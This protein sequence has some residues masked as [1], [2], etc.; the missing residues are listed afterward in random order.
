MN[1]IMVAIFTHDSNA[2][3]F[4][5]CLRYLW[6]AIQTF[7]NATMMVG[8]PIQGKTVVLHIVDFSKK[9]QYPYELTKIIGAFLGSGLP[10]EI[11][12]VWQPAF[13]FCEN[14]NSAI[15]N[16][17][18]NDY[19]S[20]FFI[21]DDA[22]V[23]TSFLV[24]GCIGLMLHPEAVFIGGVPQEDGTW[25][26]S[27][28]DVRIP[29]LIFKTEEIL[30][31]TRLWWE[32]SAGVM[33]ITKE[34][35]LMDANFDKFFGLMGDNDLFLR[36]GKEGKKVLRDWTMRFFHCRGVTQTKFGRNPF[37]ENDPIK[38]G[39]LDY[40]KQKWGVDLSDMS[41]DTTLAD[42]P[43]EPSVIP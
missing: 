35:I 26:A 34:P 15:K 40:F 20:I 27:L 22:F 32:M 37:Q 11:K 21:N 13:G 6:R 14:V 42:F 12:L 19:E 30:N 18:V 4:Q 2:K 41:K 8:S 39:A 43:D 7:Y 9:R 24:N 28:N 5:M 3:Y 31:Y 17:F 38:R 16:A 25:N 33:R 1:K 10:L 23:E 36:M 29:G